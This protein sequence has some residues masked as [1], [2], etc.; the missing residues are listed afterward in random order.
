MPQ[1]VCEQSMRGICDKCNIINI[2]G[3]LI[4]FWY[5]C[6]LIRYSICMCSTCPDDTPYI[7]YHKQQKAQ[8]NTDTA[9]GHD[10]ALL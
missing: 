1:I 7:S 2:C 5:M 3:N 6:K 8:F 10:T 9:V 4:T